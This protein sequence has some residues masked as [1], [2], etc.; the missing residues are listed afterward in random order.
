[1]VPCLQGWYAYLHA[2]YLTPG[3][4]KEKK[5]LLETFLDP[6][7][8][9]PY[10]AVTAAVINET[11][12]ALTF[13]LRRPDLASEVVRE[14]S[15]PPMLRQGC[16]HQRLPDHRAGSG[17]L[18]DVTAIHAVT[19]VA[20]AVQG[21]SAL[22]VAQLHICGEGYAGKSET[23]K[24]LQEGFY[25]SLRRSLPVSRPS[26]PLR[27]RTLGMVSAT[28]DR[29]AWLSGDSV[30]VHFHDY[31]G[32]E[33]FRANH[34]THLAAPNSVYLIVVPLWDM[35]P[36]P[37]QPVI[38]SDKLMD[39]KIITDTYACWLK[40]IASVVSGQH[41]A[42]QCITVLNFRD[43]FESAHGR[44]WASEL[45]RVVG[46]LKAIQLRF[47]SKLSF[48][49]DP[50]AINSINARSVHKGVVP[51]LRHAIDNLAKQPVPIAPSVQAV[52]DHKERSGKWPLFSYES[53]MQVLLREAIDAKHRPSQSLISDSAVADDVVRAIAQITQARLQS[54]GDIIVFSAA[55]KK[56]GTVCTTVAESEQSTERISIN[57]PNW[58]TE[59]LL[60]RIF[61]PNAPVRG[62][63]L[64]GNLLSCKEI[65]AAGQLSETPCAA[66]AQEAV[67][68]DAAV[69]GK[70]L[71]HIGACI[72]VTISADETHYIVTKADDVADTDEQYF[73]PAFSRAEMP[74]RETLYPA[75]AFE[76]VIRRY[77]VADPELSMI[78]P[79]YYAA[80]F[81]AVA[82]ARPVSELQLFAPADKLMWVYKN[83]MVL[84]VDASYRI[85]IRGDEHNTSFDL[86]VEVI[87]SEY[88][89]AAFWEMCNVRRL[90]A[91]ADGWRGNVR[92][93][94]VESCVHPH[95]RDGGAAPKLLS[96]LEDR[97]SRGEMLGRSDSLFLYGHKRGADRITKLE[98]ELVS[99]RQE[100]RGMLVRI[101][102]LHSGRSTVSDEEDNPGA[103]D[104]TDAELDSLWREAESAVRARNVVGANL[105]DAVVAE[106]ERLVERE[107][108]IL[109]DEF[110]EMR[111]RLNQLQATLHVVKAVQENDHY[112]VYDVPFLAEVVVAE[113]KGTWKDA[114]RRQLCDALR[115]HFYCPACGH[116][117]ACG[118]KHHGYLLTVPKGWVRTA[119]VTLEVTLIA[120]QVASLFTPIPLP[121]LA[122][123]VQYLPVDTSA[124]QVMLD[125][126]A[127]L[128]ERASGGTTESG[129]E[130]QISDWL[131]AQRQ[132]HAQARQTPQTS[133]HLEAPTRPVITRGHMAA[134]RELLIQANDTIPPKHSGLVPVEHAASKECAWVCVGCR[135]KFA[136]EGKKCLK[137]EMQLN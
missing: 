83:G 41:G 105:S 135:D 56:D 35:R 75:T 86:E 132:L 57:R 38:P 92:L 112:T 45:Q 42:E 114:A 60:G 116:R 95:H 5:W 99:I 74:P 69:F 7:S 46:Q 23:T 16:L 55:R 39:E 87:D 63:G 104:I 26:I 27:T 10:K 77:T 61:D 59:Q 113:A 14:C 40:F 125:L 93:H 96:L 102:L 50:V 64:R 133:G 70:L 21:R 31:G 54:R 19:A 107:R 17:D 85:I 118:P 109:G 6:G 84:E 11:D 134:V 62:E 88:P 131:T 89:G 81:V 52:L 137:I 91:E 51:I 47:R 1:V 25:K 9:G 130:Q 53:G 43:Q 90:I 117:A 82:S 76:R 98:Q 15:A 24:S 71:H 4:E 44:N 103:G 101:L 94:L 18:R 8:F 127:H 48:P 129:A 124:S 66:S 128:Q 121:R 28:L 34:A 36:R 3:K 58:L 111:L 49:F 78:P 110:E 120:L 108:Q 30:R 106:C 22:T 67:E 13:L 80:L 12:L 136:S 73:F 2:E 20:T 72:P 115:L 123:I 122:E 97:V 100:S 29:A 33:D 79:G 119:V 32:Q 65:A 126:V 68:V 37:A